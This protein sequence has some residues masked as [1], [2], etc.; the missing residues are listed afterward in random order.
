MVKE[1]DKRKK[2]QCTCD[3]LIRSGQVR[4][5]DLT[6][7]NCVDQTGCWIFYVVLAVENLVIYGADVLNMFA[8]APLPKQG[9]YIRPDRAFLEWW[10]SKSDRC[11][12]IPP[13]YV[14]P[15]MSSMH[16]HPESPRLW[17]RLI[18]K[19]L[20]DMGLTLTVHKPCLYSGLID[21]H[22]VLFMRQ[23]DDFAVA[24]P[25]EQI[26][27]HVFDMLDDRLTFPMK[28]MGFISLFNGLDITQ[29]ADFVKI[30]CSTYLDKVL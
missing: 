10:A 20:W 30:L 19:H 28:H 18:D 11:K 29:T 25:S 12:P 9:F 22:C 24:A 6:Y 3:V 13:S 2:A 23:V 16:G 1:L 15:V 17:E 7:A 21:G 27:N 4:V 8:K 26:A 5:L 14:I